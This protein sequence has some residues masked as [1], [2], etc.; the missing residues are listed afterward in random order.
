ME[1]KTQGENLTMF[2]GNEFTLFQW[3]TKIMEV[4]KCN[5]N[6]ALYIASKLL[7]CKSFESIM[8]VIKMIPMYKKDDYINGTK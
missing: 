4:E 2:L 6:T 8:K 3:I 5:I 1:E 7:Q